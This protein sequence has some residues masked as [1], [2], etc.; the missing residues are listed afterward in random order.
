MVFNVVELPK[1]KFVSPVI[2]GVFGNNGSKRATLVNE[3]THGEIL[4]K[5]FV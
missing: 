5:I 3:L 2:A 4:T 1:H